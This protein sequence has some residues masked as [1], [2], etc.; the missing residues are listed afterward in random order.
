MIGP[1]VKYCVTYKNGQRSFNV[2][3]AA[4]THNFKVTVRKENLEGS[5]ALELNSLKSIL[6]TTSKAVSIYDSFTY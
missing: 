4:Y 3:R 5:K 1:R 2:Y 6:V